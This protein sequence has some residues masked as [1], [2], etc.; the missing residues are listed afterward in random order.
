LLGCITVAFQSFDLRLSWAVITVLSSY[1][2]FF[3]IQKLQT[4]YMYFYLYMLKS[5]Y[6]RYT[7][8]IYTCVYTQMSTHIYLLHY[9]GRKTSVF[10]VPLHSEPTGLRELS[11][12]MSSNYSSY[13]NFSA[14]PIPPPLLFKLEAYLVLFHSWLLMNETCWCTIYPFIRFVSHSDQ[15]TLIMAAQLLALPP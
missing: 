14:T 1:C 15:N 11:W 8:K 4:C 6:I 13:S 12:P 2:S 10:P 9:W 5:I 7:D 3:I